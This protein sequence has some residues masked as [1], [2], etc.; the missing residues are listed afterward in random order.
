M[1][2][3]NHVH[4]K[5]IH[6]SHVDKQLKCTHRLERLGGL[7]GIWRLQLLGSFLGEEQVGQR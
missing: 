1:P 5:H 3:N 2:A 6:S 7:G 4:E